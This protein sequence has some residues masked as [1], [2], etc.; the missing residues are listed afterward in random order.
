MI[1]AVKVIIHF[2]NLSFLIPSL[3]DEQTQWESHILFFLLVNILS[4]PARFEN[5]NVWL[6]FFILWTNFTTFQEFTFL[7][8]LLFLLLK[9]Y[10]YQSFFIWSIPFKFFFRF[11]FRTFFSLNFIE[12]TIYAEVNIEM[13]MKRKSS[14]VQKKLAI[15]FHVCT[16]KSIRLKKANCGQ[17]IRLNELLDR[18]PNKF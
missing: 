2:I 4:L 13:K 7:L 18:K 12:I 6:L 8:R 9:I 16:K 1:E 3:F 14:T 15:N 11:I 10:F 5:A 17:F